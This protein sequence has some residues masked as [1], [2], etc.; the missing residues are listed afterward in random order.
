VSLPG[1]MEHIH[2]SRYIPIDTVHT[3][4]SIITVFRNSYSS[5]H[6]LALVRVYSLGCVNVTVHQRRSRKHQLGPIEAGQ[7]AHVGFS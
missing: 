4:V 6:A 3:N 5:F 2:A 7:E 1:H